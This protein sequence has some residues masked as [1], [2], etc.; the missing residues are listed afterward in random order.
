MKTITIII[1]ILFSTVLKSQIVFN[2]KIEQTFVWSEPDTT[3]T[4]RDSAIGEIRKIVI[5]AKKEKLTLTMGSQTFVLLITDEVKL[6]P[7]TLSIKFSARDDNYYPIIFEYYPFGTEAAL[8]Y[9]WNSSDNS[10]MKS[11]LLFMTY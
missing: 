11:E 8:Y 5:D 2:G 6:D 10:F 4:P 1:A 7:L 9:H 3:W